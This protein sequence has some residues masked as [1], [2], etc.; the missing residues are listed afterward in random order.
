MTLYDQHINHWKRKKGAYQQ[1][2]GYFGDGQPQYP[3]IT[4]EQEKENSKRSMSE[5]LGKD[6]EY[7]IYLHQMNNGVWELVPHNHLFGK[8]IESQEELASFA[9][10]YA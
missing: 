2:S 7:P 8:M 6:Y 1:C 10:K 3:E 4:P 5:I 9:E